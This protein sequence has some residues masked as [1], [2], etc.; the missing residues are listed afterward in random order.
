MGLEIS[1]QELKGA[2]SI[3][4]HDTFAPSKIT[5]D[6]RKIESGS[7][8]IPLKG[9][10]FDGHCYITQA[11]NDGASAFLYDKDF[12]ID[13]IAA[14]DGLAVKNTLKAYQDLGHIYRKKLKNTR[15][16]GLTG[17]SG[18]TTLKEI[19]SL[20]LSAY[21]KT[22]STEKNYNNEIGVPK[23]LLS[24]SDKDR[25]A[26]VEMGAR[27]VLDIGPLTDIA[28]PDVSILTGVG[29]SHIGEFGSLDNIYKTKLE[30]FT[31]A[32]TGN[33]KI[34]PSDDLRILEVLRTYPQHLTVGFSEQ[35]H[36]KIE[37]MSPKSGGMQI[38][39]MLN[40][41]P[42]VIEIGVFHEALPINIGYAI[43]V[44]HGLGMSTDK[45]ATAL[46]SFNGLEGR[47]QRF[48]VGQ[49]TCIDDA[50]NANTESMLAG[51]ESFAKTFDTDQSVLVLGDMLELGDLSAQEHRKIGKKIYEIS[52]NSNVVLV[53]TQIEHTKK[54]LLDQG[55]DNSK[56]CQYSNY[57]ELLDELDKVMA[58]G[59]NFYFKSS[60]GVGIHNV[61]S[62]LKS[63]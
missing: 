6:S 31:H 45:I 17:S 10:R 16:I 7:L 63:S 27:H 47:Y 4:R 38:T 42:L 46:A 57:K 15:F 52:K 23:T 18:K 55:F 5:T 11:M 51:L 9:E 19:L 33:L 40:Q 3:P 59:E 22:K 53:G 2:S 50:Y 56:I 14:Q 29:I 30:I 36:I 13:P 37:S 26:V 21:G 32:P 25:F 28:Q 54:E 49:K 1:L 61:V 34:G 39:Y 48:N 24:I 60:H 41:E 43:A 12:D 35:S 44:V 20:V 58:L 62:A 8:F